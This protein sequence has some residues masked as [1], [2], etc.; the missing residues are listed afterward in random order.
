MTLDEKIGQLCLVMGGEGTIPDWIGDAVVRGRVGAVLNEVHV[1]T[2]NELQRLATEESRLGIP[3]LNGRDVIHGFETIF[4]LPLGQAATWNPE[5]VER[6]ARIA[7]REAAA[8]GAN[9]SYAPMLDIGRDP[10]WGRIA[11]TFGEDPYMISVMGAAMVRG[12]Q[13]GNLAAPDAVAA[14]A[15][16]FAGYGASEG[17]RDYNTT[18]IPEHEL[19]NVHLVP[20]KAA[21]DAGAASLMASFSDLNGVPAT[22]NRWLL[23]TVLR[24]EWGSDALTVSDWNSVAE[25]YTHGLAADHRE[26]A[27]E[28]M[29]AGL[30]MEMS[31]TTYIDHVHALLQA[32][33]ITEELIDARVANV[34][35][36]KFRL[37]LFE[38]PYTDPAAFPAPANANHLDAARLAATQSV[39]LL[40]N[41][42]RA[43]PL[44]ADRLSRLAVIGPLADDE[45]EQLGTWAFD[46]NPEHSQTPLGTLRKRFGDAMEIQYIRALETTRSQSRDGFGDAIK[47][48]KQSDAVLLFLGE[49]AILSGEAHCR[50]DIGLPGAQ[51][52][53]IDALAAVGTPLV[54]VVMAGRPLTLESVLDKVDALLFAWHP[55]TMAGPALVD[56]LF[57]DVSPSGKLPV[58]FPRMVGQV[59]LYYAHKHTGRPPTPHTSTHI[60]DIEPRAVQ[61][62]VGNTSFYLDAGYTPLFPFGFGLSYA[63]FEYAHIET[64]IHEIM[65]GETLTVTAELTNVGD[66]E[67]DEVVQLYVRDLAGSVTRPVRELKGF[68]RVSLG[69]GERTTVA[70]QLHTDD[71]A[72]YDRHMQ[73]VTE[74][75]TF[76]VWIGGDSTTE[77]R[78]EF[79]V[80]AG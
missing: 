71:L 34:L 69:P 35:R 1:D 6:G 2:V 44:T 24:D 40:K 16:H 63:A 17:G 29:T 50:A 37:D 12:F 43:L 9:W 60:D 31:S 41:D 76:H 18:N 48:A 70:F 5:L 30:D 56:L 51:E 64:S 14:C 58:T 77:L 27:F 75:G 45:Y 19:R 57:G 42:E 20:F 26:A 3:L 21:L 79:V 33:R 7:A 68:Q 13:G 55:G 80:T 52:A 25:L 54:L 15:K 8:A 73:R 11:E 61:T 65:L 67:A 78:T 28:A 74:P 46:G 62:S 32:G 39:V 38:N 47:A 72:F 4:P 22:G 49:E 59:P 53:L 36:L 23:T 66:C 10:R